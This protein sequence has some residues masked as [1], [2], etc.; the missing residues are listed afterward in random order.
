MIK[1]TDLL[2]NRSSLPLNDRI[3]QVPYIA[4]NVGGKEEVGE[5]MNR[6]FTGKQ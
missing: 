1:R 5:A 2:G 4:A 3:H 6:F